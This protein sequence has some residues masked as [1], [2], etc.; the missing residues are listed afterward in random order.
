MTEKISI[1]HIDPYSYNPFRVGA[2]QENRLA[3]ATKEKLEKKYDKVCLK[4]VDLTKLKKVYFDP[5]CKFPRFKLSE[6]TS[7][8]RC[9]KP[10]KADAIVIT[11]PTFSNY[12]YTN[13]EVFKS[14][15]TEKYYTTRTYDID[16]EKMR[17]ILNVS[18]V[19]PN[20]LLISLKNKELIEQ[21]TIHIFSGRPISLSVNEYKSLST[22][23]S[24]KNTPFII[25]KTLDEAISKTLD[26]P[27]S[28]DFETIKEFLKSGDIAT[29]ELGM[30][31]LLNYNVLEKACETGMLILNNRQNILRTKA[32]NSVG[33]K[34][35]LA[36]LNISKGDLSYYTEGSLI[37]Y[38]NIFAK[39]SLDN[40]DI[41]E[42]RNSI[43]S[44]VQEDLE[45]KAEYF[46]NY[47]DAF[48]LKSNITVF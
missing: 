3:F 12:L 39:V 43:I 32:V 5:I 34:N 37:R 28:S 19:T 26:S 36:S 2:E 33:F 44:V 16:T 14:P 21:D 23:D 29:V 6:F 35:L 20:D 4:N 22:I 47:L 30:K 25:D 9:I 27:E 40:G 1:I 11:V 45:Q 13:Y 42:A 8:K 15:S 38:L 41:K 48:D 17:I 46:K 7:I 18:K 24:F 31:L 10:E